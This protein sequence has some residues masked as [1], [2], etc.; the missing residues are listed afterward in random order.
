[1]ESR[2]GAFMQ[3]GNVVVRDGEE[4][5]VQFKKPFDAPPRLEITGFV[6]SWFK[7]EPYSKSS[8]EIV[9]PSALGFKIHSNHREQGYGSFAEIKW[10][11]TGTKARQKSPA[12]M[13]PQ[14]RIVARVGKLGG[15]VKMDDKVF[16]APLIEIDLHQTRA[17]DADLEALRGLTTLKTLNLYGTS[18]TDGGLAHL[19]GLTSLQTLHLNATPITDAGLEHLRG[20]TSLKELSLYETRVTD[21]GLRHVGAL[22]GLQNLAL[23]GRQIT[24][25]GL[26]HLYGLK[27]LRLISLSGTS[28]TPAGVQQLHRTWPRL[29]VVR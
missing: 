21:E 8:F 3:E 2:P 19:A 23:G 28:V 11:A 1:M 4:V 5:Q 24:D 17:T 10:R 25:R 18:I 15:H 7:N 16:G 29:Q 26:Q 6:Q 12:E 9:Q 14:E 20:L 13:S 22:T 27:D